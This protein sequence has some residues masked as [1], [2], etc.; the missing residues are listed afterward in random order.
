MK[1]HLS[2]IVCLVCTTCLSAHPYIHKV[3]EY[4]PAPG[5]FVNTMPVATPDDTPET[6]AQKATAAIANHHQQMISLG[7]YGGYV[8][9]GFDH[10]I[11]NLEG[12]YDLKILGNS[13]YADANP[14]QGMP[15]GGNSEPGIVMV[16]RDDNHN[17]LPDDTWYELAGSEYRKTSTRH[18]YTLSYARPEATHLPT[19]D[20]QHKFL[21]DTTYISWFAPTGEKGYLYKNAYHKQD[22][23]P[24]WLPD[25]ISFTGTIMAPNA[26]DESQVGSYFV[27]YCFDYGYADNQPNE[28][29]LQPDLHASE[30]DLSWAVDDEGNPV[31]LDAIQFVKVS[32]GLNQY[33]GWLG[34]C[35]TEIL[36]AY[37]LH[38]DGATFEYAANGI[39][40]SQT[41]TVWQGADVPV[42]GVNT[43]QS[44]GYRFATYKDDLYGGYYYAFTVSS[45]TAD[46]ASGWEQ[47]Y[48][49]AC[50]GAYEG[51]NFCVWN[52]D[53][54]GN[55]IISGPCDFTNLGV[56]VT[57]TA[58]TAKTM[59]DSY[60][61][62]SSFTD[63]D[64]LALYFIG[65]RSGQPTDTVTFYLA[66]NGMYVRQWTYVDL[67]PLGKVDAVRLSI[68]GSDKGEWG[69]NT[70]QYAALDNFG[71]T[72][73]LN[74]VA[75]SMVGFDEDTALPEVLSPDGLF[76]DGMSP[77][78]SSPRKFFYRGT[79]YILHHNRLYDLQ[80]R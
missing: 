7:A 40:L 29:P 48:R 13:F 62:A 65:I 45:E 54:Y 61:M 34:E 24:L 72:C 11:R 52:Q 64:W 6:M 42:S 37:D 67:S 49:S 66:Q 47:P 44:G 60:R 5:Q 41:D 14:Q 15:R 1:K 31:H 78:T 58:Y 18:H 76:P 28:E 59:R 33:N 36:D 43:W 12:Q 19:P 63:Q 22:Y 39:H 80:G 50:G 17:G 25:T 9:F 2:F 46:T 20:K 4:R 70:P 71:M 75:P 51:H 30:F 77:D 79:L 74:Y 68:D 21:T 35:S 26:V 8:V 38:P 3:W 56:M 55:N 16:S 69:L 23:Y 73:P 32:T 10:E 57:N 53:Y 27:S